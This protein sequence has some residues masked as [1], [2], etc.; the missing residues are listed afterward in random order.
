M[1][2]P[3]VPPKPAPVTPAAKPP[4]PP[5]AAGGAAEAQHKPPAAAAA[6]AALRRRLLALFD[7]R[8]AARAREG[9]RRR[10]GARAVGDRGLARGELARARGVRHVRRG[11]RRA[12]GLAADVDAGRL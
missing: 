12:S 3:K 2:E 9:S 7:P 10:A 11:L 6:P 1:D 5:V 4:A 8:P